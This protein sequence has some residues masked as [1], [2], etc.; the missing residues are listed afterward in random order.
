MKKYLVLCI[1]LLFSLGTCSI[2]NIIA[3]E[4][5]LK[6]QTAATSGNGSAVICQ[7]S[8]GEL[9]ADSVACL[10]SSRAFKED[11]TP[12]DRDPMSIIQA[13]Q[14]VQY[15]YKPE[16]IFSDQPHPLRYGFVAEDVEHIDPKLVGYDKGG[17][18]RTVDMVG[19]IPVLTRALQEQQ[20]QISRLQYAIEVL[21]LQVVK[22]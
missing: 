15:R 13:L 9:I 11:I 16:G 17:H 8:A 19:L 5:N 18:V 14:P 6:L 4:S 3:Q 20:Q 1:L 7:S 21:Q 22:R 12:L 2:D 10:A